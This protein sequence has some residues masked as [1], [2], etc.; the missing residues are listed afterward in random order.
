MAGKKEVSKFY[1]NKEKYLRAENLFKTKKF[2]TIL[3]AYESLGGTFSEG[4]GYKAV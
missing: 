2:K 3:A 1:A 4:R